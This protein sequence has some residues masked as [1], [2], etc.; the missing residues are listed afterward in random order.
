LAA[1]LCALILYSILF[2][3]AKINI[4]VFLLVLFIFTIP[5]AYVSLT[6]GSAFGLI[7]TIVEAGWIHRVQAL[8]AGLLCGASLWFGCRFGWDGLLR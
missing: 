2:V 4:G 1:L 3:G 6:L 7:G 5:A 8:V